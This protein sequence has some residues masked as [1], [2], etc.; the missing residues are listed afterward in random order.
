MENL[1]TNHFIKNLTINCNLK[2]EI[3]DGMLDKAKEENIPF[4]T[5]LIQAKKIASSHLA[6]FLAKEFFLQKKRISII[7]SRM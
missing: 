1:T 4:I 7:F 6:K 5:Y 2:R 3:I